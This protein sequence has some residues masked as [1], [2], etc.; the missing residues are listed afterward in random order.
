M[1]DAA[2]DVQERRFSRSRRAE[3]H[4]E[5]AA[6]CREVNV[7][8]GPHLSRTV[9]IDLGQTSHFDDCFTRCHGIARVPKPSP[10]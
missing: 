6:P 3:D 2:K 5:F 10:S 4:D 1:I 9:P 8:K 7:S